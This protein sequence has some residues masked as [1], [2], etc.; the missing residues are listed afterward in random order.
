MPFLYWTFLNFFAW[1]CWLAPTL[2]TKLPLNFYTFQKEFE[3]ASSNLFQSELK[4]GKV[5]FKRHLNSVIYTQ[6]PIDQ[7][8]FHGTIKYTNGSHG[9]LSV[10]F[11]FVLFSQKCAPSMWKENWPEGVL[12]SLNLQPN[13]HFNRQSP[14]ISK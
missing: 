7:N 12:Y 8:Y 4:N 11:V 3:L 13:W 10:F 6:K 5:S 14:W 1:L 9:Y 2:L